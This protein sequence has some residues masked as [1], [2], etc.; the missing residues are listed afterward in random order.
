MSD[1]AL[2]VPVAGA[3][4]GLV[5]LPEET[6]RYVTRVHRMRVGDRFIA[7]DPDQAIEADAE[8]VEISRRS[9]RVRF[10]SPRPAA[11]RAARRVTL[12][13]ALGKGDKMD[14][15]VRDA[16]E[17]GATR[18]IPAIAERSVARPRSSDAQKRT[19]RYRRIAIEAARQCQRGDAPEIEAP[20]DLRTI[21][22]RFLKLDATCI[23]LDPH[24][25]LPFGE[26]LGRTRKGREIC[27]LV[28]PEGG[29][30][31]SELAAMDPAVVRATLGPLVLRTETVCAAALGAIL[32][33]GLSPCMNS[34]GMPEQL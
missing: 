11:N 5:V 33:L 7:F 24:A 6:A 10:E 12:V 9:C 26:A 20:A 28:G 21:L 14:Q 17:L 30:S 25:A 1:R 13:Q 2:R 23:C 15:V 8:L 22:E 3:F 4:A 29:F 19:A 18:L 27:L 16:T 32:V 31:P 34:E